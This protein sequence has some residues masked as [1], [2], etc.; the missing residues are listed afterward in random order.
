[1]IIL[2]GGGKAEVELRQRIGS[3]HSARNSRT[4]M[5][6][7]SAQLPASESAPLAPPC[8]AAGPAACGTRK[9]CREGKPHMVVAFPGGSGTRDM[10]RKARLEGIPV[11][12]IAPVLV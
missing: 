8:G 6:R 2:A 3:D 10:V 4:G 9:C 5:S 11:E 7:S 1:M 12:I